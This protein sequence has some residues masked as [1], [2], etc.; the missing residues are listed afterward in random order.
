[1][2]PWTTPTKKA[3]TI[4]MK[5]AGRTNN[6]IKK[7]LTGHNNISTSTINRIYKKYANK[8]NYYDVGHPTGRPKK[9]TERDGRYTV[10]VLGEGKAANATDLQRNFF[11]EVSVDTVKREL[12]Q[13]SLEP[14]KKA[15]V[16]FIRTDN[17]PKRKKWA[18]EHL[19][20]AVE[21]WKAVCFSDEKNFKVFGSDG[22]EWCWR[23]KGQ[24]LDPR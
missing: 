8:E 16:P 15:E 12:R 24:R 1:M 20:W 11:P 4:T 22:M 3:K 19:D 14:H 9:L 23:K 2:A 21:D 6:E 13:H 17:L 18:T 5:K 7:A 10:R